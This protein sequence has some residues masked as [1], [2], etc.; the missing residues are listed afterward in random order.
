[1]R[2]VDAVARERL[3]LLGDGG[4]QVAVPRLLIT[5]DPAEEFARELGGD[6]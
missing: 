2:G 5:G 4:H 1:V 6:S 3:G